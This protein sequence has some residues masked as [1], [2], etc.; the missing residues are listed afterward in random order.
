MVKKYDEGTANDVLGVYAV[1]MAFATVTMLLAVLNSAWL[2][3]MADD[4][5]EDAEVISFLRSLGLLST[6]PAFFFYISTLCGTFGLFIWMFISFDVEYFAI[7][8]GVTAFSACIANG[9]VY[10]FFIKQFYLSRLRRGH[11]LP[12]LSKVRMHLEKTMCPSTAKICVASN[13]GL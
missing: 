12:S 6:T 9:L 2:V 7:Q 3:I 13:T 4:A 1:V 10:L 8:I 11:N 5:D